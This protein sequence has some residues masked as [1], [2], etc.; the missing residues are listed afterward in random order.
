MAQDWSKYNK[1]KF[2][3]ISCKDTDQVQ[4][5]FQEILRELISQ[6]QESKEYKTVSLFCL[7]LQ[8]Y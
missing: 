5:T 8:V 1:I 3:E 6:N 2:F 7:K 4:Q